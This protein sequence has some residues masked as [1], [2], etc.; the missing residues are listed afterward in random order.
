MARGPR[1]RSTTG[2]RLD[3]PGGR[4][5][6]RNTTAWRQKSPS[7]PP[8][9]RAPRPLAQCPGSRLGGH[10]KQRNSFLGLCRI[11]PRVGAEPPAG[12]EHP[13]SGSQ[14]GDARLPNPPTSWLQVAAPETPDDDGIAWC[15]SADGA[16][17]SSPPRAMPTT[18]SHGVDRRSPSS[19]A[20][21]DLR[22]SSP[23]PTNAGPFRGRRLDPV[24]PMQERM[25]TALRRPTASAPGS[26]ANGNGRS[27]KI[28]LSGPQPAGAKR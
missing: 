14:D 26:R 18:P 16:Q 21:L 25:D 23:G 19:R 11:R 8:P 2:V 7:E 28:S 5:P 4:V 12:E 22:P 3:A 9:G 13:G 1:T 20:G 17:L 27:P 6:L 24:A 15:S 10:R